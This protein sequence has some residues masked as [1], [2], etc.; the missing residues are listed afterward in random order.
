ME[1]KKLV[2]AIVMALLILNMGIVANADDSWWDTDWHYRINVS[3]SIAGDNSNVTMRIEDINFANI[4]STEFGSSGTFDENSL[5][6]VDSNKAVLPL[7][8]ENS[9]STL[10]NITWIANHSMTGST[11]Y[12]YHIYFDVA[13]NGAKSEGELMTNYSYWR[14][15]HL[16]NTNSTSSNAASCNAAGGSNCGDEVWSKSWA[17][18]LKVSYKWST[19]TNYDYLY[20]YIDDVLQATQT[21]SSSASA[22][23]DG[24]QLYARYEADQFDNSTTTDDHGEYG[25]AIEYIIFYPTVTV[26]TPAVTSSTTYEAQHAFINVTTDK[27][28]YVTGETIQ[29]SGSTQDTSDQAI[30]GTINI[31]IFNSTYDAVYSNTTTTSSGDYSNSLSADFTGADTYTIN[32]TYYNNANY[33]NAT[34]TTT[35]TYSSDAY[36]NITSSEVNS[37]GEWGGNYTF[38]INVTDDNNDPVNI[39]LYIL[40]SGVWAWVGE[41]YAD[42]PATLSWDFSNFT[43]AEIGTVSYKYE[44]NDSSHVLINTSTYSGSTLSAN[45]IELIHSGGNN[46][47]LNRSGSNTTQ[48]EILINDTTL[49][50]LV[51]GYTVI[52]EVYNENWLNFDNIT[53]SS[54]NATTTFDPDCNYRTGLTDW[55]ASYDSTCYVATNSDNFSISLYGD[56]NNSLEQF[57][58]SNFSQGTALQFNLTLKDECGSNVTGAQATI[59]INSSTIVNMTDLSTG[60]Y[61]YTWDSTQKPNGNYTITINSSKEYYNNKSTSFADFFELTTGV[62]LFSVFLQSAQYIAQNASF[63]I[64]V[65]MLDQSNTNLSQVILSILM[66]NGTTESHNLN[67]T[68]AQDITTSN[69]TI[70]YPSDF[71]STIN[72][73][74]YSFNISS[75]DG[76][77]GTAIRNENVTV[78]A[79]M[80]VEMS[81]LS[82]SY[83]KED[84][85]SIKYNVTDLQG[86][87][88][89]PQINFSVLSPSGDY[90]YIVNGDNRQ[91]NSEGILVPVVTFTIPTD[92]TAGEYTAI[93]DSE[94]YDTLATYTSTSQNNYTFNVSTSTSS[95]LHVDIESTPFWY[96]DNTAKF[97]VTVYSGDGSLVDAD[98]IEAAIYDPDF[99]SIGAISGPTNIGTGLYRVQKTFSAPISTTG[100]YT[101]EVNATVGS[102]TTSKLLAFRLTNGGPFAFNIYAPTQGTIGQDMSFTVNVTNEGE[103]SV[104]ALFECWVQDGDTVL[105]NSNSKFDKLVA[106]GV[107]EVMTQTI[108]VPS[109]LIANT[110]YLLKCNLDY[111]DS[112]WQPSNATDSFTA[113][114]STTTPSGDDSGGGGGGGVS[115]PAIRDYAYYD[116]SIID[117]PDEILLEQ[118]VMKSVS[119]IVKNTGNASLTNIKLDITGLPAD[120]K[121]SEAKQVSVLPV[122]AQKEFIFQIYVPKNSE[123]NVH[124][125]TLLVTSDQTEETALV[126]ARVF[127]TKEEL[128]SYQIERLETR[129]SVLKVRALDLDDQNN[130]EKILN[131][132]S[133]AGFKL[134]D[135]ESSLSIQQF[136]DAVSFLNQA[137]LLIQNAEDKLNSIDGPIKIF[138]GLLNWFTIVA[139]AIIILILIVS[140]FYSRRLIKTFNRLRNIKIVSNAKPTQDEIRIQKAI[141]IINEQYKRGL[142][143]QETYQE[144]IAHKERALKGIKADEQERAYKPKDIMHK[145]KKGVYDEEPSD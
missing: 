64:N 88:L 103:A 95:E 100:M 7:D 94:I 55:R 34:N 105:S 11:N 113:V 89:Q 101:L 144:L 134:I 110:D 70:N 63:T 50:Q 112:N 53:S 108:L 84:I 25:G 15:G 96:G 12:Y 18:S 114:A 137:E 29:V 3:A 33:A 57:A 47:L 77:S 68:T 60:L 90:L 98:N 22:T 16:D 91:P 119:I 73:G 74:V 46:S 65:S 129:I 6:V 59:D 106:A 117:I 61:N 75:T 2:L 45:T 140:I 21:G 120:W 123:S 58:I 38:T 115:A 135:A 14:S 107:T 41:N 37:S 138:F 83:S 87:S 42:A 40:K 102:I 69:W 128:I 76:L 56:F 82:S 111:Q 1:K 44:Y 32:V 66:P 71:G 9:S 43:C 17:N 118:D 19:E 27:S 31:T 20:L 36:P 8:F 5:R 39:S 51:D 127:A 54:G 80:T 79:N 49:G 133:Q 136:G 85:P 141:N 92:A 121:I 122:G 126:T 132:L 139:L 116:M 26:T 93:A 142:L 72:R 104:E 28:H 30:D 143:T 78:Y 145:L 130:A 131:I 81:T 97:Y 86:T 10:G 62:P 23:Y 109:S 48:L 24:N 99:I 52:F 124:I 13:E 67:N 4:L 125:A 35:F